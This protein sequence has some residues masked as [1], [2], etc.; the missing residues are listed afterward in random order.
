MGI[1]EEKN[2]MMS[3]WERIKAETQSDRVFLWEKSRLLFKEDIA[4]ILVQE[5][6]EF[7]RRNLRINP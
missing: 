4:N 5:A 2:S 1:L 6:A 7:A 3:L